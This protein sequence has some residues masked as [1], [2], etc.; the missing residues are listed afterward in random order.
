MSEYAALD[1]HPE[2][3]DKKVAKWERQKAAFIEEIEHIEHDI[4]Q[5][6]DQI[7]LTPKHIDWQDL[8]KHDKFE[9]ILPSRKRLIDTIKMIAY[10]AET[11]DRKKQKRFSRKRRGRSDEPE[12]N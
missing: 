11:E 2:M 8:E 1:L 4:K 7:E 3:E 12:V 10:R 6:K 9:R 5:L